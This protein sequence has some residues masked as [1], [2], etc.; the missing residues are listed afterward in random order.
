MGLMTGF[1]EGIIKLTDDNQLKMLP[2]QD[3]IEGAS[4]K[5]VTEN[6]IS[7]T[8]GPDGMKGASESCPY[9]HECSI[10]IS[11]K[12]IAWSLMQAATNTLARDAEVDTT[13]TYSTVLQA[14][15][16]T[17]GTAT[18]DVTWTPVVG[19]TVVVADID[20]N[21]YDATWT[22]GSA[23]PPVVPNE[24][25]IEGVT[26]GLKVTISYVEAATGTNN[27]IA[28]G[29]GPKLG[30]IGFYGRFSGCPDTYLVQIN[31]AVIQANLDMSVETE[32]ATA[33]FM[34]MA[35]R[36]PAGNF[37]TIKRL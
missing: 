22:A 16:I 27:E 21:Q 13:R 2:F 20:G 15:D 17:T 35:L 7:E 5:Y 32:A 37:A 12:N 6:I 34:A 29:T 26:A 24:L 31:R 3:K 33:S 36:D 10:E 30:E 9:R 28:L 23:G 11:S 14:A 8:F 25:E 1:I 19:T 18:L 4:F